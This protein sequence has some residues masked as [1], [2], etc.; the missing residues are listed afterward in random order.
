MGAHVE[1]G[2]RSHNMHMP[3]EVNRVLWGGTSLGQNQRQSARTLMYFGAHGSANGWGK[4][5]GG[6]R[7]TERASA[8]QAAK[9]SVDRGWS[10]QKESY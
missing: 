8:V 7:F 1:A 10:A 3:E 2:L 4:C 6:G 5:G 9:N